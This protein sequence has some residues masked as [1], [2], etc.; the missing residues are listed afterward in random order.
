MM[1]PHTSADFGKLVAED[2]E[3]WARVIRAQNIKPE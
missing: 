1:L 3:K 2:T